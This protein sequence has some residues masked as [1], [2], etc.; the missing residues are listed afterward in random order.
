M[1]HP[2]TS[3]EHNHP[4]P[5]PAE[6]ACERITHDHLYAFF[7]FDV[8]C[9]LSMGCLCSTAAWQPIT[10]ETVS[11]FIVATRVERS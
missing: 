5:D 3:A 7:F 1:D 6:L 4:T 11:F 8:T 9:T 10:N 2:S